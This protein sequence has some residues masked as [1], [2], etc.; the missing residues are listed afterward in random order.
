MKT[1]NYK[2]FWK[3]YSIHLAG[4]LLDLL[5]LFAIGYSLG[6]QLIRY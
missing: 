6:F 5:I 4:K 2:K 1:F 3:K